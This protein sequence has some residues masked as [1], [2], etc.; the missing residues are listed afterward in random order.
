MRL[1]YGARRP[2]LW[3]VSGTTTGRPIYAALWQNAA[4][5]EYR[6]PGGCRSERNL[7]LPHGKEVWQ[8]SSID[9]GL[10]GSLA[11]V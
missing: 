7:L 3:F 11:N 4:V 1:E 8:F 9:I 10:L 2:G 6:A 5:G